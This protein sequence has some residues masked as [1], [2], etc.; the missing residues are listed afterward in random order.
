MKCG[1]LHML[2]LKW[3]ATTMIY[4]VLALVTRE[5]NRWVIITNLER[6]NQKK[7]SSPHYMLA[8]PP[9]IYSMVCMNSVNKIFTWVK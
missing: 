7:G 1:E 5:A 3:Q 2:T 4:L 6:E 9:N 8:Q